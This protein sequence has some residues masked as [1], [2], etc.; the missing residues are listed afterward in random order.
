MS[1]ELSKIYK[2]ITGNTSDIVSIGSDDNGEIVGLITKGNEFI[3]LTDKE[4][5]ELNVKL[6]ELGK[7]K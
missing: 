7:S 1:R 3:M 6:K 5:K 2:D 4:L